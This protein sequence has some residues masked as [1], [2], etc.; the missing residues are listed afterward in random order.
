[1]N[2]LKLQTEPVLTGATVKAV[3]RN[4]SALVYQTTTQTFVT[5]VSADIDDYGVGMTEQATS[6]FYVGDFPTAITSAGTYTVV[7]YHQSGGSLVSSDDVIGE[8]EIVWDGS[9]EVVASTG[10]DWTTLAY[11]KAFMKK[12]DATNDD[13]ISDLITAVSKE[14]D[15]YLRRVITDHAYSEFYSLDQASFLLLLNQRP[16][17]EISQITLNPHESSPEE[18]D[19]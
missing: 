18:I 11:V 2:E 9:E 19:G 8:G 3:I 4:S 5:F 17:A 13:L 14:G 16:V 10:D 7:V 15:A 1:V 12:T 6:G